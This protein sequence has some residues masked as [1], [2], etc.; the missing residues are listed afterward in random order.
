M[1]LFRFIRERLVGELG[2]HMALM[3]SV[4]QMQPPKQ[5]GNNASQEMEHLP[6]KEIR[7]CLM[8]ASNATSVTR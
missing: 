2:N 7:L 4:N 8:M 6:H 3:R 5:I 1:V